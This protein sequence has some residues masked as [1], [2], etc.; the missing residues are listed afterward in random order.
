MSNQVRPSRNESRVNGET[1]AP[2][3]SDDRR[4]EDAVRAQERNGQPAAGGEALHPMDYVRVLHK[5]RATAATAFAAVFGVSIVYAFTATPVYEARALI[6]IENQEQKVVQFQQVLEENR[7]TADY[8]QTQYRILQSRLLARRTL[9]DQKLWDHPQFSASSKAPSAF[10]PMNW[11]SRAVGFVSALFVRDTQEERDPTETAVQ[12][13]AIDKLL[14][15]LTVVPVRNSRLVEI[16]FR[17]PNREVSAQVA[18]ALARQYIEQNLEFRFMASKEAT[19]FLDARMAEQ[20]KSLE[21]SEQAL[22]QYREQTG[23]VALEDRQNIVVQ[24]LAD[25]NGAVTRA[26]TDRI[27]KEAVYNQ[28]RNA[29]SNRALLDTVPAILANTFIQQLKV[30]IADLQRQQAQLSE[31]LGERHPEMVKIRNAIESTEARIGVE[32]QKSV[33][34]LRN[35]YQAALANERT[36]M[37]TLEQ[38]RKEAQDLNRLSI[39]YGVLARNTSTNREMFDALL[40]RSKETGVAGELRTSNIRIVD[41]AEMPGGPASPNKRNVLSLGLLGGLLLGV[42]L[43]FF[44]EYLDSCIK[45]PEELKAHL[46]LP[47]LGIIPTIGSKEFAGP[48]LVNHK[49]P[50][51]FSEAFRSLRT[52]VMFSSAET[53]SKSIVVTSTSPGEG[54]TVVSSNLALTLAAS[55]QR[56]LLIDAD[57]RR[58]RVHDLFSIKMEPGLSNVLV[59]EAK[60]SDAVKKITP[61]NLWVLP[62]GKLPPNPAELLGSTRFRH[63][64][65]SLTQHFDWIVLDTPPVMP[66]TDAS[67]LAHVANGVIYVVG[68]EMTTRGAAK[69]ALEHLDAAKARYLGGVLNN[70]DL[71]KNQYYYSR[72]YRPGYEDYYQRAPQVQAL[73]AR[74]AAAPSPQTAGPRP[75]QPPAVRAPQTTAPRPAQTAAT[76]PSQPP[77]VRAPQTTAPRPAQTAAP[78]PSQTA[79]PQPM[80]SVR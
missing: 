74:T 67:V 59:G 53:G 41:Q 18:N 51:Q 4:S 64:L 40:Q 49:V 22:Q 47:Y 70:V 17:S 63:F 27:E 6:Q 60:A 76:R 37:S 26:R 3:R 52:N 48:T 24:R 73:P 72:Y 31:K 10:N 68:S 57:M 1:G 16:R 38:Q 29:Q 19:E 65:A 46:G 32:V 50:P 54:K 30:Q 39:Q 13:P 25:L 8:Y 14:S 43:A 56:V 75:S 35:D 58:P 15:G 33:Q 23:A 61:G 28:V 2:A 45:T 21:Q 78:R 20:R 69:A 7:A 42:G 5:R 62:A 44:F 34:A 79:A 71:R 9:E 80:R 77:A 36:L 12:A 66:V 55:G 11:P